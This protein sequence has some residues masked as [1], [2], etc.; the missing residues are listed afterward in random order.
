MREWFWRW[1]WLRGLPWPPAAASLLTHADV[2]VSGKDGYGM[3][4]IPALATRPTGRC[5]P[6][7]RPAS[8]AGP[9]RDSAGKRSTWC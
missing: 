1:C 7:P 8:S 4:R 6:S 3:Y 5:W 9:I 2:F